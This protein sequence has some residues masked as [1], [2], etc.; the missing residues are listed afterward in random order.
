MYNIVTFTDCI[1]ISE[2]DKRLT[3]TID[4]PSEVHNWLKVLHEYYRDN[5]FDI[6]Y[7]LIENAVTEITEEH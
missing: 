5:L 1:H 7:C 6:L 4:K 2:D 3:I